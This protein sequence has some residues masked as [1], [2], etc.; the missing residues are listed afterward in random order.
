MQD[1]RYEFR[2]IRI[3]RTWVNR[4]V[5]SR[6]TAAEKMQIHRQFIALCLEYEGMGAMVSNPTEIQPAIGGRM[7]EQE[8]RRLYP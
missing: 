4:S 1:C 2:R 8:Q 5:R 6:T 7:S 3:P